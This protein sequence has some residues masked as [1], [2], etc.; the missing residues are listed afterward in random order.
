[1][2]YLVYDY[3]A[4]KAVVGGLSYREAKAFAE[5]NEPPFNARAGQRYGYW[6]DETPRSPEAAPAKDDTD[7]VDWDTMA[8]ERLG[9]RQRSPEVSDGT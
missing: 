2:I 5:K 1:M 8:E 7:N 3:W 6:P 4:D 9:Q